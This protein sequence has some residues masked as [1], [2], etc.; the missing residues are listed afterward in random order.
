MENSMSRRRFWKP[1]GRK[2]AAILLAALMLVVLIAATAW[3]AATF[4]TTTGPTGVGPNPDYHWTA[5]ATAMSLPD[6]LVCLQYRVEPA[7]SWIKLA[8]TCDAT[9]NPTAYDCT[10]GT[11]IWTCVLPGPLDNATVHWR[12]GSWSAG[13]GGD[14]CGDEKVLADSGTFTTGPN[15]VTLSS[16]GAAS[17][18]KGLVVAALAGLLAVVIAAV[19][20]VRHRLA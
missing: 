17:P 15:A 4:G 16:F 20:V 11:G 13:S 10:T 14:A 19:W 7:T 12:T 3:A 2:S 6:K 5:E 9:S 1:V 8:C 18:V